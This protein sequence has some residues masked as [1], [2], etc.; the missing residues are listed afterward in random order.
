MDVDAVQPTRNSPFINFF[1]ISNNFPWQEPRPEQIRQRRALMHDT[2]L[3]DVLLMSGGVI[4]PYLYYPPDDPQ[5]L[6]TLLDII[7]SSTYDTLKKDC[8]VYYLLKWHQDGRE[9][10]FQQQRCIPPQFAALSDAYWHL[11]TGINVPRAVAILSDARINRDYASKIIHAISLSPNSEPLIRRYVQTAKPLLIEPLDIECYALALAESSIL[12]A[13]QFSR[14]FNEADPM[15]ARLFKKIVEW[16]VTPNPRPIALSQLIT[17]PLSTFEEDVFNNFVQKPPSSIK[18]SAVA[19]LQDLICVRLIQ[20]GRYS[21]AIKL[22]HQFTSITSPKNLPLTKDRSKMVHDVYTALP[23]IERSMIDSELD[24]TIVQPAPLVPKPPSPARRPAPPQEE[25]GDISLSQSW[26]DVHMPDLQATQATPL[27]DV[28]VPTATPK[29]AAALPSTSTPGGAP[30][31]PINFS[32]IASTSKATPRKSLPLSALPLT[33]SVAKARPSLSGVG[34]RMAFGGSP[35]VSSPASGVRMPALGTPTFTPASRQQNAFYK[36]PPQKTN[37]VKRAFEEEVSHSPERPDAVVQDMDVDMEVQIEEEE[38]FVRDKQNGAEAGK[39]KEKPN[40]RGRRRGRISAATEEPE[41][42]EDNVLQY[43]VFGTSKEPEASPPSLRRKAAKKKAPPG[44]FAVSEDE[45]AMD[46][47]HDG[48]K[49]RKTTRTRK[50]TSRADVEEPQAKPPA[51][52]ARQTKEKDLSRSIP[53]GFGDEEP[54]QEEE[55][56]VAPLRAPSPPRRGARKLRAS[57]SVESSVDETEGVKTRRRS[58]RLT[59]NGSV[60]GGSPE[61]P[62]APKTRKTATRTAK[63]KKN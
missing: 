60:H 12:E 21:E 49:P 33:S 9:R 13:W 8:L 61:P 18:F 17:L 15:R 20:G 62:S 59:T 4:E 6:Q 45:D 38:V 10:N 44:S 14:T 2:L 11:D 30:I 34:Q 36:P 37:G 3:F 26:E 29:F 40:G 47:D 53:G 52:K 43:S 48:H 16:T 25:P 22:D 28:R 41:E 27:R 55:D 24:P 19:I 31:L 50:S 35:A 7:E 5:S 23:S 54:E 57:L 1:D 63:K 58:S 39:E 51:K 56:Q 46:E 32:G 42:E